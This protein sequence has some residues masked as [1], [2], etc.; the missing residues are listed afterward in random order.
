VKRINW[1]VKGR[2]NSKS[3]KRKKESFNNNMDAYNFEYFWTYNTR[4]LAT[5]PTG[6]RAEAPATA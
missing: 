5:R 6:T 3:Y 1:N 4:T 2:G